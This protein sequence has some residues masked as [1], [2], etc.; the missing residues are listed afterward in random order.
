MTGTSTFLNND[1]TF[2]PRKGKFE[3]M[4]KLKQLLD[5]NKTKPG[6]VMKDSK[7]A[8]H[9]HKQR[10]MYEIATGDKF[11]NKNEAGLKKP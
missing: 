9:W 2:N 3:A 6:N 10:Q 1:D 7:R 4:Q 5:M 11:R 8:K